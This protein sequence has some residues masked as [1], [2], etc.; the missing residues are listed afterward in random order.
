MTATRLVRGAGRRLRRA[1]RAGL[2][3]SVGMLGVTP[4]VAYLHYWTVRDG[5]DSLVSF[6]NYFSPLDLDSRGACHAALRIHD[7]EG[8]AVA[9][10]QI[11]VP[12]RGC[13]HVSVRGLVPVRDGAPEALEG[14]L[15]LDVV[16]PADFRHERTGAAFE[17][18]AARF[19]MLY[20]SPGGVMATA[21]CIEKADA[22]RGLP[23]PLGT[24]LSTRGR[25]P[26]AWRC[27]RPIATRG[28]REVR[29]VVINYA[30][31]PRPLHAVLRAGAHGPAV[32]EVRRV[33]PPRGVLVLEHQPEGAPLAAFYTLH[34]DCLPT[35]NGKP[36]LWV[37]Y[38]A[39]PMAMHHA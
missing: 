38:G 28:L 16:A 19:F 2:E 32:A 26:A 35:P 6:H 4:R 13:A 15:E 14:S 17:A 29:V 33:V 12:S 23:S 20:R 37:G 25:Q 36:Y 9:A 11:D 1:W 18:S 8:R 34:S 39:G 10:T 31:T 30:D 27:K 21:H 24:L 3:R 5:A 22:Y 7:A